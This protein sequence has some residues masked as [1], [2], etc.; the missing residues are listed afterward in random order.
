MYAIRSYYELRGE[1]DY[2][3]QVEGAMQVEFTAVY[4][5][6]SLLRQRLAVIQIESALW[7][8][9]LAAAQA[10]LRTIPRGKGLLWPILSGSYNFV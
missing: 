7:R 1:F 9:D 2:L 5:P 8:G 4:P 10:L 3:Q 6:Q